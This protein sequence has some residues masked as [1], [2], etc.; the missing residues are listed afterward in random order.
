MDNELCVYDHD[1]KVDTES[2][3]FDKFGVTTHCLT[4]NVCSLSV[5]AFNQASL[6]VGG[7]SVIELKLST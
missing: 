2:R 1:D 4:S 6:G 7:H 3:F 5:G